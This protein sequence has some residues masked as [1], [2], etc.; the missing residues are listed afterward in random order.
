MHLTK[1]SSNH[2][3]QSFAVWDPMLADV[4]RTINQYNYLKLTHIQ[5]AYLLYPKYTHTNICSLLITNK[6]S[7]RYL[8]ADKHLT[9]SIVKLP[10]AY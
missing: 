9:D 1:Y 4:V 3:T 6:E 5:L 2:S 10:I 7:V 8:S